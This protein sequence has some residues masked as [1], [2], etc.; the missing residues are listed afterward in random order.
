MPEILGLQVA[1]TSYA[2]M[3]ATSLDWA[4]RRESRAVF[5]ANVHV[6]MEAYDD[7]QFRSSLNAGDLTCPDGVPLVWALRA[8]GN[9]NATRV[10]GPDST[11]V[12]LEA[13]EQADLPVGFYGGS[14]EVLQQL[15]QRVQ[16]QHPRLRIVYALSPPFRPLTVEEDEKI[17]Q[18]IASSGARMLF[19]GLGC[20]KQE[21]WVMQHHGRIPAVMFAVGA[22]FDF[23]AGTTAQAPRWMMRS[24]LEWVFRFASEP[25]RLAR[26]YLKH[27]PRY[28]AYFLRQLI[29]TRTRQDGN[30]GA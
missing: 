27:N 23:I 18:E 20:P 4:S 17:T 30:S 12:L 16:Q 3:A 25:R 2:E 11:V 7:P 19:V 10:Y 29:L 15:V 21:K 22:A 5:F 6:V 28:V 1:P 24:G 9:R 13:A 14:P 26:R 8:L